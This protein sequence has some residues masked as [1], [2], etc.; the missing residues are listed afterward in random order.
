MAVQGA[1]LIVATGFLLIGVLG[2]VPAATTHF[3][4]L[5]WSGPG[6]GAELF[7]V[8]AIC[9]LK[10]T[11]HLITGIVGFALARTYA[12]SRAYF[13]GGGLIYLALW[14]HGLL[15]S[16][17]SSLLPINSANNW[18]HFSVGLVMVLLGLTLAG[19]RDPTKR[20]ARQRD[21][22]ERRA[23]QRDTSRPRAKTGRLGRR[24]QAAAETE[25][26]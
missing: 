18:L 7:G 12:A 15:M 11:L 21:T 19:Q 22:A 1:A 2:F 6:S 25:G 8:F 24:G 10:N 23:R 3:D 9:G 5:R 16:N 14:L 13:L 17:S 20:R 4:L 26:R